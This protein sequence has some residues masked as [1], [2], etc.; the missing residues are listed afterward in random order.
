MPWNGWRGRAGFRFWRS[1]T[2]TSIPRAGPKGSSGW[3]ATE[4]RAAANRHRRARRV[5]N[6][7]ALSEH[8]PEDPYLLLKLR[9]QM[10]GVLFVFRA[11]V[12]QQLRIGRKDLLDLD[13]PRPGVGLRIVDRQLDL[14]RPVVHAPE[15]FCEPGGVGERSGCGV[16][17]QPVA[18]TTGFN[19]QSIA[20]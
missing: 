7:G 14:Q 1:A 4:G 2:I 15:S 20:F 13:G 9:R 3:P 16:H 17:P 12:I 6:Y 8:D 5:V 18:E 10:L 11:N 19:D